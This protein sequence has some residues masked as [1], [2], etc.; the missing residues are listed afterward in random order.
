VSGSIR[1]NLGALAQRFEI[2][3]QADSP[4]WLVEYNFGFFDTD[5]MTMI[6]RGHLYVP[7]RIKEA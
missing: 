5:A 3:S 4:S 1:A 2:L 6:V 7:V